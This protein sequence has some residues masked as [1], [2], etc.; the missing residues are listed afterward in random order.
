[1]QNG[2]GELDRR[3]MCCDREDRRDW[4]TAVPSMSP[5][6]S[7][8][9]S[10]GHLTDRLP[11]RADMIGRRAGTPAR[12]DD[13]ECQLELYHGEAKDIVVFELFCRL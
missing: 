10:R 12:V 1:M 5:A 13:L 8:Q 9:R 2:S 3:A 4:S 11:R 7:T 6:R